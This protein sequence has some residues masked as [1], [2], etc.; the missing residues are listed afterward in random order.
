MLSAVFRV[1][2]RFPP[3]LG[4]QFDTV[5]K[6]SSVNEFSGFCTKQV[7]MQTGANA[8]QAELPLGLTT[9]KSS[10]FN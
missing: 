7:Q 6:H 1:S 5:T 3:E 9:G 10:K 4:T 2:L 8:A